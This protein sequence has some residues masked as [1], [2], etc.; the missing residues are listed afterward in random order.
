MFFISIIEGE[1]KW[2]DPK[3][4]YRTLV[5]HCSSIVEMNKIKSNYEFTIAGD[6]L[7]MR[8]ISMRNFYVI[9]IKSR[10]E[11]RLRK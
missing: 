2:F 1:N 7:C 6:Y 3:C 8:H 4:A 11:I 10:N 9:P 5:I